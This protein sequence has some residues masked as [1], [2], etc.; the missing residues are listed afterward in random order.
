MSNQRFAARSTSRWASLALVLLM[1]LSLFAQAAAQEEPKTVKVPDAQPL[2]KKLTIFTYRM[3]PIWG[4]WSCDDCRVPL[5]E[6]IGV[7]Q[8]LLRKDVPLGGLRREQGGSASVWWSGQISTPQGEAPKLEL[9]IRDL[10]HAGKYEGSIQV[11][12]TDNTD[13]GKVELTV[14]ASDIVVWPIIVLA[15][16]ILLTLLA[17]RYVGVN[18]IIWR[19][20]EQEAALGVAF[21]ESQRRFNAAAQEETYAAYSIAAS[22]A[23]QRQEV[24][25]KI[26]ALQDSSSLNIEANNADYIALVDYLKRLQAQVNAWGGFSGELQSLRN[27]LDSRKDVGTPPPGIEDSTPALLSDYQELLQG[28]T[29][30]LDEFEARRKKIA[31][32]LV[33]V[34]VWFELRDRFTVDR[35]LIQEINSSQSLTGTQKDS[36]QQAQGEIAAAWDRLWRTT[37]IEDL[38]SLKALEGPLESAHRTLIQLYEQLKVAGPVDSSTFGLQDWLGVEP[39]GDSESYRA[40]KNML[41]APANDAVRQEFYAAARQRWDLALAVIAFVTAVVTGL[42][43]SYLGQPFGTLKDYAGLFIWGVGTKIV[44]DSMSA[45]LQW[46]FSG[47]LGQRLSTRTP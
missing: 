9:D 28:Q 10:K 13:A 20:R 43:A 19:L 38:E 26:D 5:R 35:K 44:V 14:N 45:A 22:L 3:F 2:V 27:L 16:S 25:Q 47:A 41:R 29:L 46:I 17:K 37:G 15:L 4:G 40:L 1:A 34:P 36:F 8:T 21:Q 32:A 39:S 23:K 7:N 11:N 30:T 33:A 42:H 6:A 24:I 12:P 31:A 18:R